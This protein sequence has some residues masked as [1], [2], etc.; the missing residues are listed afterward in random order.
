[1]VV[2]NNLSCDCSVLNLKSHDMKEVD[3]VSVDSDNEF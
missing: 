2:V 1:M 3:C